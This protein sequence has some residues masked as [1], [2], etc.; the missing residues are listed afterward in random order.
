M[1]FAQ[2]AAGTSPVNTEG[3]WYGDDWY[4]DADGDIE[5]H[6]MFVTVG[7]QDSDEDWGDEDSSGL[8]GEDWYDQF[9]RE[10]L[11]YDDYSY[12]CYEWDDADYYSESTRIGRALARDRRQEK[13]ARSAP[14]QYRMY[15]VC[16]SWKDHGHRRQ[17]EAGAQRAYDRSVRPQVIEDVYTVCDVVHDGHPV[18]PWYFREGVLA[19]VQFRTAPLKGSQEP[20]IRAPSLLQELKWLDWVLSA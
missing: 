12:E 3:D 1:S 19:M 15:G 8:W 2:S 16:Q 5:D 14:H 4:E 7:H 9:E 18:Q 11:E 10:L 17:W 13:K 6:R 20:Y